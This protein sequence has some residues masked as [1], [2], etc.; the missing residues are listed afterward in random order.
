MSS[1]LGSSTLSLTASQAATASPTT[2]S[3]AANTVAWQ[4]A[5]GLVV[6]FVIV[7]IVAAII[8]HLGRVEWTI[9]TSWPWRGKMDSRSPSSNS[10][11]YTLPGNLASTL[12]RMMLRYFFDTVLPPLQSLRTATTSSIGALSRPQPVLELPMYT[13]PEFREPVLAPPRPAVPR[14]LSSFRVPSNPYSGSS[15]SN[16]ASP[17]H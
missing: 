16:P 15:H 9:S 7:A 5:L 1:T 14:D 8:V 10:T 12:V 3:V 11:S 13:E 17:A 6:A 4:T 2:A